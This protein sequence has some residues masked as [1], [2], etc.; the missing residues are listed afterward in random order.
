[1]IGKLL[2]F[3]RVLRNNAKLSDV[4]LNPGGNPNITA[5]HF[6]DSGDDSYPMPDDYAF[7]SESNG[8]GRGAA[9]GYVDVKNDQ[10]ALL[11]EKRIYARDQDGNMVVEQWLKNTGES[12]LDNMNGSVTLKPDGETAIVN[13]NGSIT[14]KADGTTIITNPNG[15]ITLTVAGD[16]MIASPA[17]NF[18]V[19]ADGTIKGM[20]AGG[21]FQLLPSG[22]FVANGFVISAS[23][24]AT[25]TSSISAPTVSGTS[26]VQAAGKELAGH[27]HPAGSPPGNTGVNN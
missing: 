22:D 4:K 27:T 26:S 19:M 13:P 12:T 20:N 5:E 24:G 21:L 17:A 25:G 8:T 3:T 2:S 7:I 18:D 15:S 11:G 9:V 10:K 23:G 14:L 16:T 1:M 6:A